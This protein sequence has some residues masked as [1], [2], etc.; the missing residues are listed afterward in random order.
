[1]E[2]EI[3]AEAIVTFEE[4]MVRKRRVHKGYRHPAIDAELIR[5]R[6]KREAR[7]LTKLAGV[8]G[9]P[10]LVSSEQSELVIERIDAPS[11]ERAPAPERA[12]ELAQ[13][14]FEIHARGIAHGDVTPRNVLVGRKLWL[15]DY[16]LSDFTDRIEDQAYDIAMCEETFSAYDG[17]YSALVDAY[18]ALLPHARLEAFD[19]R[20]AR[21][22]SRGRHKKK[23]D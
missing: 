21:I 7:V 13:L 20:L 18:R 1:M 9:V 6:T 2:T 22:R 10:K 5:S 15:I 12:A 19:A 4:R 14:L 11:F 8:A 17:F 3:G 23:A 16:G